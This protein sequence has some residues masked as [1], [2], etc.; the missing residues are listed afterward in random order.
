VSVIVQ[1][2]LIGSRSEF[3]ELVADAREW[4]IEVVCE[5]CKVGLEDFI[6]LEVTFSVLRSVARRRLV[7][8]RES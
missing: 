6:S 8:D 4:N 2:E 5:K 7:E 3:S 1:S